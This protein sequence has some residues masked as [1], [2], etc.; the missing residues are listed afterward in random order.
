MKTLKIKPK[1]ILFSLLGIACI[2]VAGLC[3]NK[4]VISVRYREALSQSEIIDHTQI[5]FTADG[6]NGYEVPKNTT[7]AIDDLRQKGFSSIKIDARLTKDKKWVS[8]ADEKISSVTN[9]R[10][11]VYDYSYYELLNYNIKDVPKTDNAV[12]ELVQDTVKYAYD[13]GFQPIIYLHDNDKAAIKELVTSISEMSFLTVSIASEDLKSLEYIKKCLPTINTIYCV[14]EITDEVITACEEQSLYSICFN[15]ANKKNTQ[16]KLDILTDKGIHL[17][18][19]GADSLRE[20]EE[21]YKI[22][23]RH[24]INDTVQIGNVQ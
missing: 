8:L 23:I 1:Y 20:M 18:C 10:G 15:A 17:I 19:T 16:H 12:I 5:I 13:N 6:G 21:M 2:I 14:D 22:G 24:F 4:A 11:K 7:Y 9:G 3:I